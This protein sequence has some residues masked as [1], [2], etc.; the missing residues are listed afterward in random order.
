MVGG[1]EAVSLYEQLTDDLLAGFFV[2]ISNNIEEGI[3]SEAMYNELIL[4]RAAA[5]KRGLSIMDLRMLYYNKVK[6]QYQ[7]KTLKESC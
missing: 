1:E 3:L 6:P 5:E 7:N 4:I 2:E